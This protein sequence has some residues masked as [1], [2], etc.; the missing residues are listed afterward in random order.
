MAVVYYYS[1]KKQNKKDKE[2]SA[3]YTSIIKKGYLIFALLSTSFWWLFGLVF[4][5]THSFIF[6]LIMF[7][8]IVVLCPIIQYI[9]DKFKPS[10]KD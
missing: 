3:S 5:S 2:S 9:I 8:G 1:L 4:Y 10:K 6:Y 7:V